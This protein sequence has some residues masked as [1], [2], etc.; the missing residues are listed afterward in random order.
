MT[1]NEAVAQ[2]EPDPPLAEK[3]KKKRRPPKP[4]DTDR[5]VR[6]EPEVA[7]ELEKFTK[8]SVKHIFAESRRLR[9][10]SRSRAIQ[11]LLK[12]PWAQQVI[13]EHEE[14]EARKDEFRRL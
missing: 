10:P 14:Q 5:S 2:R 4:S 9:R 7:V 11:L 1:L 12:Q 6:L 13:R 3:G 8:G